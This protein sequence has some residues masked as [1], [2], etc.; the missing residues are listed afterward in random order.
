MRGS[1]RT[2][3]HHS[4]IEQ[5]VPAYNG[6]SDCSFPVTIRRWEY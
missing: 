3:G 6:L 5:R 2:G 1:H 4:K